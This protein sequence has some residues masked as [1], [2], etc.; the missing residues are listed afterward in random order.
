MKRNINLKNLIVFVFALSFIFGLTID[1]QAQRK[2]KPV[3][4]STPVVNNNT[5]I[6]KGAADVGIQLKNVTK[7]V[8]ILGGVAKGIEAIDK[9]LKEGKVR[10]DLVREI[11]DKNAQFKQDVIISI[12]ALR[13]GL[14]KLEVDFRTNPALRPYLTN[15]QGI[16]QQ[17]AR[18]E[19]LA[20][21]GQLTGAGQEL[22]LVVET[23]TDTLVA[24]P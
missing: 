19:D 17:S 20:M 1:S 8:F 21:M 5:E 4:K 23:L 22:L 10:R 7:F 11:S 9:D 16:I 15:I 6:K 13:A 2:R 12:R 3:K 24:M 14:V 18:A